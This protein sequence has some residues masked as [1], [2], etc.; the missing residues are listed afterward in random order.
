MKLF[1]L[2]LATLLGASAAPLPNQDP[3]TTATCACDASMTFGTG[4]ALGGSWKD[5]THVSLGVVAQFKLLP[6]M[7]GT[8]EDALHDGVY[9]KPI[10][11]CECEADPCGYEFSLE[12]QILD[13]GTATG[14]PKFGLSDPGTGTSETGTLTQDPITNQWTYQSSNLKRALFCGN[15]SVTMKL[16]LGDGTNVWG[17]ANVELK[18]PDCPG[19]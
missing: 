19:S 6:K 7:N 13:M 18:C 17:N 14:T 5:I 4:S 10:Q 11:G 12:I 1:L 3:C 8:E 2:F 16:V 9:A 15:P